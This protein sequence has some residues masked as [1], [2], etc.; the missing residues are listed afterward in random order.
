LPPEDVSLLLDAYDAQL[1]AHVHDRLPDSIQVERDGPLVRTV[2]FGN[3][4][5]VEYRDLTGLDGEELDALI[6]RQV[7]FFEE[8]GEPS[9]GSC[10][11]TIARPTSPPTCA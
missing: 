1:R 7:R 2:G 3:H 10:T 11:G 5:F 8:R 6:A 4:E 9:N